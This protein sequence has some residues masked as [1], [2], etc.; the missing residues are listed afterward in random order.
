[1]YSNENDYLVE[2]S[3]PEDIEYTQQYFKCSPDSIVSGVLVVLI[4]CAWSLSFSPP[5]ALLVSVFACSLLIVCVL[6][7]VEGNMISIEYCSVSWDIAQNTS[8]N[9]FNQY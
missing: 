6:C 9:L 2:E 7:N 5:N 4:C 8:V 1:M 3:C